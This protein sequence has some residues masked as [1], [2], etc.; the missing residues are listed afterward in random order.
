MQTRIQ[1][2]RSFSALFLEQLEAKLPLAGDATCHIDPETLPQSEATRAAYA[3]NCFALDLYE[4][5]RAEDGNLL[6][7]P[8][9]ISTA[10]TMAYSGT[11]GE[12]AAEMEEV[13][14]LGSEPGIHESFS[15]LLTALQ[16]HPNY[17]LAIANAQ[18]PQAG[19]PIHQ[20][21]LELIEEQYGG[22]TEALDYGAD[23][24]LARE[25]INNWVEDNTNGRIEEL[26]KSLSPA[27]VMV[28]TNAIFFRAFWATPF[29]PDLTANGTFHLEDGS[30]R[31]VSMMHMPSYASAMDENFNFIPSVGYAYKEFEGFRVLEMPY[32][33][34]TSSMVIMLPADG[35]S[36]SDMT[37]QTIA[38]VQEWLDSSP[39]R[40]GDVSLT[41]PAFKTTVGSKLEQLLPDMGMPLAFRNADFS[42][43]TDSSVSISEVGH[44]AF[45]EVNE[46][47]TEAAAATFVAIPVCF[48][49]GTP[50]V[51][52]AGE[53]P[54]EALQPGDHVLSRDE[55]DVDGKIESMV[56]EETFCNRSE[57][58]ELQIAGK[59][60]RATPGHPFFVQNRG[61]TSAGELSPGDL[62]STDLKSWLMVEDVRWLDGYHDVF[63]LRVARH[64]TYFV[65][66]DDFGFAIWTHNSCAGQELQYNIDR[67][68]HFMIRDNTTSTVL[69]MGRVSDP[70]VEMGKDLK[71]TFVETD[72]DPPEQLPADANSDGQ[73]NFADFLILSQNY[74]KAADATFAEGDFDE[75]GKIDFADFLLL[76]EHFGRKAE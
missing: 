72:V 15:A 46:Q 25:T 45:I 3:V 7:S 26:I 58:L 20:S 69:F 66:G 11:A 44:K 36:T 73:V 5:Y 71:P 8:L 39:R 13:L 29:A 62:L 18:W 67:P 19:F 74:G 48:A 37:P 41:M 32:Q 61:W 42:R 24:E 2:H 40:R 53:C 54:I 51:T 30:N 31:T 59:V 23:V 9:S 27:T 35:H 75:D 65:G 76:T 12:T 49:A 50:V 63:N 34:E 52:P 22:H 64:H 1:R 68:F 6:L 21:F 57:L 55:H 60:I 33:G 56:V 70:T 38:D 17:D 4:H 16:S 43:M 47:G 14:H 10:L 28:L